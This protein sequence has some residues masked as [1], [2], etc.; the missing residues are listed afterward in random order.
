MYHCFLS[1]CMESGND[2]SLQGHQ[3]ILGRCARPDSE[4]PCFGGHGGADGKCCVSG[5]REGMDKE[6][7]AMHPLPPTPLRSLG[8]SVFL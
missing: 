4:S 5:V 1:T 3:W 7:F 2:E 8:D 6:A